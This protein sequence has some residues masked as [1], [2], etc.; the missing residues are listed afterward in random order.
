MR[1]VVDV[2][3]LS[4]QRTGVGNYVRG[5]LLGLV[6][7]SAG[8]HELVAF[9]PASRRGRREIEEALRGVAVERRL[10]TMPAA[11]ALRTLW[12]RVGRPPAE[13][14]VG[15]FDVLHF[16]DWMYPPQRH[17][18]RST[19]VHD[20]VPVRF[21]DWVHPRTRRMHGA[22]YTHAARTCDVVMVNSRFTGDDVQQMLGVPA[23]RIHVAY[24]GIDREFVPDGERT[25]LDRPYIL[26]VATLE[27][28][29]NLFTLLDA[30]ARHGA[31]LALAVAGAA[32]WGK[33]PALEAP[34][35]VP[36]GYTPHAELPG[37]Y[38]GASVFVY[39]SLFEGFGMPV[40][41]AMACGVPCVV[42]SHA[43]LDEACGDA[44]VRVDP[45]DADA[46]AAGIE[47]ALAD[48][49]E[50][51]ARGLAH[52]ARFTWAANGHAH[53]AAWAAA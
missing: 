16:S 34:G 48:R 6:E 37:L 45:L 3:P 25:S 30:H 12:S 1:I 19:M 26:T 31:D 38:R 44:A 7:A 39:P 8:T 32:G 33:Q 42:S 46:I 47:R 24:P 20:L 43:S 41:E 5:S 15:P 36:L 52:A 9:A 28:R 51:A 21:P 2:S 27:P 29:K 40:L 17:G 50:L 10:P 13:S 14:V 35:V 22:K 49:E 23:E 11:H 18:L 53:L 4:H